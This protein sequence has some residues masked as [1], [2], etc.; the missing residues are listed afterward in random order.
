MSV[1]TH[2]A[3]PG[4]MAHQRRSQRILL[5][6]P[7]IISG[8]RANGSSFSEPTQTVVVNAHGA[9]LLL[10]EPVVVGQVLN[11]TNVATGEALAC[12]VKD[13]NLG[14]DEVPEIGIEF[15]QPSARFWRVSFPPV[16]WSTHSPEAK[17]FDGPRTPPAN[18]REGKK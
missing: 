8:K 3:R 10:R 16:G 2:N 7:V 11:I 5:S 15:A 4:S 9:L 1:L 14:Q 18:P 17:R 6:V 12:H 13:T